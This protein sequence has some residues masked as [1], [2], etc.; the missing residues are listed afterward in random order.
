M[1]VADTEI[2]LL[3]PPVLPTLPGYSQV[4]VAQ[5]RELIVISGQV[6]LDRDGHLVG[7]GDFAAQADQTFRNVMAAL[8]AAGSGPANLIKLT[9]FLTDLSHLTT[10]REVRDRYLDAT[11]PPASTLVG[12][13]ALFRPEFLIEIEALA[14]R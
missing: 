10:F 3:N 8:Q 6:A 2:R 1:P 5:A 14:V 7:R 12:V 9:T 13:T 4:V 11:R